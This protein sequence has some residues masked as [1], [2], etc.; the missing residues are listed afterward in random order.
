[1]TITLPADH[2]AVVVGAGAIG[3][4]VCNA[5][6]R[7]GAV[8]LALDIDLGIATD[9]ATSLPG[10][11]HR[12]AR[13]DV[14]DLS[15][16]RAA[17]AGA[18]P[19]GVHSLCFTAGVAPTFD[20]LDFD[21]DGYRRTMAVNLDG[22]LHIAHAFGAAMVRAGGGSMSFIS[23]VAGK[24]G[25]AGAAA[26]CASKFALRGVVES[27]AA[28]VGRY[29]VRV[30]AICPGEVDTPMLA[31]VA[32]AQASRRGTDAASELRELAA[33][34]ALGRL[35]DPREVADVAVWLASD[36]ASAI[37]GASIDVTAG[38]AA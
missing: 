2:R 37:T 24:H 30:N 7:A 26:Y 16:A 25:A 38:L 5:Y 13:L 15:A 20:V 33:A 21:W 18:A 3:A 34:A 12:A 23:S 28:E 1:M 31:R 10:V 19:D 9:V 11:G 14:T 8:V 36:A 32:H 4:A 17:A 27:F 35:V 29:G 6:A 22:A